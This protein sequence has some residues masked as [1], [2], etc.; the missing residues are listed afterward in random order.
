MLTT[1]DYGFGFH[2][3]GCVSVKMPTKDGVVVGGAY[4]QAPKP[5]AARR[6]HSRSMF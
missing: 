5:L 3:V 6:L 1:L 4:K 2:F